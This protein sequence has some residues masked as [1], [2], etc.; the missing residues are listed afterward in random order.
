MLLVLIRHG[1]TTWNAAERLQGRGDAPLSARGRAQVAALAGKW[2]TISRVRRSPLDRAGETADLLGYPHADIDERWTELD[3]GVWT[4]RNLND[5]P[6]A[7]VAE[8]RA[9]R[10]LPPGAEPF[11]EAISRVGAAIDELSADSGASALVVTHG[12][13][14]RAAVTAVVGVG[15]D[16]LAPVLPASVTVLDTRQRALVTYGAT[17]SVADGLSRDGRTAL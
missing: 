16:R 14:V 13:T 10:F 8:W 9:G 11:D 5:L 3:L 12:G 15:R 2:G 7:Q 4:G 6:A 17:A 1:E